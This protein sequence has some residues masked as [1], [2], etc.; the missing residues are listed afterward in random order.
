MPDA[1]GTW[2]ILNKS[3]HWERFSGAL[4]HVRT[5]NLFLTP[6]YNSRRF[7]RSP[8]S[9]SLGSLSWST[10]S[11]RWEGGSVWHSKLFLVAKTRSFPCKQEVLGP[12]G[13]VLQKHWHYAAQSNSLE[14]HDQTH[15]P[16]RAVKDSVMA[17][18]CLPSW[19]CVPRGWGGMPK[20]LEFKEQA[21]KKTRVSIDQIQLP[22]T[23]KKN[24]FVCLSNEASTV[25]AVLFTDH[26][27]LGNAW[28]GKERY[29]QKPWTAFSQQHIRLF[30]ENQELLI[31]P[32]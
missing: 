25:P 31:I 28:T 18:N 22:W 23:G 7:K 17:N 16:V 15:L 9:R 14:L 21:S 26:N 6:V 8:N 2:L 5:P 30:E 10:Q 1:Q 11:R 32:F 27:C 13:R 19:L 20:E 4:S 29:N 12:V 24:Y 3:L